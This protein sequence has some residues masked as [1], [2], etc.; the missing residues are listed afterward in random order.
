MMQAVYLEALSEV[1]SGRSFM[2]A[3]DGNRG[4]SLLSFQGTRGM[5]SHGPSGRWEGSRAP[6]WM[7]ADPPKLTLW[8]A[9]CSNG[10]FRSAVTVD[11]DDD[12]IIRKGL[13]RLAE[14]IRERDP[15][16]RAYLEAI[17]LA[18]RDGMVRSPR[19]HLP[20]VGNKVTTAGSPN[21][22]EWSRCLTLADLEQ[23][24]FQSAAGLRQPGG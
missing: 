17:L 14:I 24:L 7:R 3:L 20:K 4:E 11:L 18:V 10:N 13:Y 2:A 22:T 23:A 12:R 5:R 9:S 16:E 15:E 6:T 19:L 21:I 1:Q 8:N